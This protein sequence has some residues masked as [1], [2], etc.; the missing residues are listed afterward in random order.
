MQ[1]INSN[2]TVLECGLRSTP[3][4]IFTLN[5]LEACFLNITLFGEDFI[6]YLKNNFH[7]VMFVNDRL[8]VFICSKNGRDLRCI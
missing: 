3:T 5:F 1:F 4:Y 7:T 6:F 2:I 8:I